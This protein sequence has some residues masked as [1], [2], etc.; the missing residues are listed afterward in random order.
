MVSL[1]F[2]LCLSSGA[3]S[4]GIHEEIVIP[5]DDIINYCSSAGCDNQVFYRFYEDN[6]G[7]FCHE[8]K[9]IFAH[10][11]KHA[12]LRYVASEAQKVSLRET[13]IVLPILESSLDP[14]SSAGDHPG[15]AKGLWQMKPS[16]AIDMGLQV[17]EY[18]DERM[19]LVDST[20]AGLRYVKWLEKKFD[21]DHNLAVLS[22]HVGI[23]RVSRM[24]E[25]Y[26][27]RNPWF[28]SRLISEKHPDK[29]YLLKYYAYALSLMKKGC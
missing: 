20:E 5:S 17:D 10:K 18:I 29:N 9:I 12:I 2:F 11:E 1:A 7:R 22:Y 28:L 19:S 26:K 24:I 15:A 3:A 23:G 6:K 13:T 16:T 14:R 8:R 21:G 25:R 4:S 27:T